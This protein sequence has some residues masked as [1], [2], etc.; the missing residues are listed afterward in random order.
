MTN[1]LEEFI[2]EKGKKHEDFKG[3]TEKYICEFDLREFFKDKMILKKPIGDGINCLFYTTYGI[4]EN[5]KP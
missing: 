2:E 3:Y 5:K 1:Q 4:N